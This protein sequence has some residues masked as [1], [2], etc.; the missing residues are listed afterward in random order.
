MKKGRSFAKWLLA[1]APLLMP[2]LSM[3][4]LKGAERAWARTSG[5]VLIRSLGRFG[6][7][8]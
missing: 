3:A 1:A 4:P 7:S 6:D 2:A 8:P 5:E